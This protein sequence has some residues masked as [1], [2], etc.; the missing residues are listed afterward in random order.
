M[1]MAGLSST[2]GCFI[3]SNDMT[4]STTGFPSPDYSLSLQET[5]Q[6]IS[7]PLANFRDFRIYS[8]FHFFPYVAL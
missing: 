1:F 3:V 7:S 4:V 5:L 2:N 6:F 8:F